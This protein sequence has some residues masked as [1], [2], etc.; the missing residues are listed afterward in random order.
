[1]VTSER[2][3]DQ[4]PYLDPWKG[5]VMH[6]LSNYSNKQE[7]RI[8]VTQIG[9]PTVA[10]DI[11]TVHNFNCKNR[12]NINTKKSKIVIHS[13]PKNRPAQKLS[14]RDSAIQESETTTHLEIERNIKLT[15]IVDDKYRLDGEQ[16]MPL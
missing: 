2:T 13:V 4:C 3:T 5:L 8:G 16:S 1:M 6:S 14:I 10:D 15:Q 11:Q 9:A 7:S 12:A